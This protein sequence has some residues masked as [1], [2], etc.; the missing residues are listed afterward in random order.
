MPQI[1]HTW[2]TES[3]AQVVKE[4]WGFGTLR[5]H[6]ERAIRAGLDGRDSLVVMPTGGGKSLCYQVPPLLL[7]RAAVVVSPLI[8][9]MKD[10]VDGLNACG[11]PAAALNS[12]LDRVMQ[13]EIEE[14][15]L[16]GELRLL[17]LAPERLLTSRTLALLKEAHVTSFAID[18]AH[19]ISHWG[20]D[21]RP[22]YRRLAELRSY[23]PNASLHAFT[24]TATQ[25]VQHDIVEQLGLRDAELLVGRCDR[26]NLTYRVVPRTDV[27]KQTLDVIRRHDN[28]AMIIYCLSRKDTERLADWLCTQGV[29]ARAYHAGMGAAKRKRVQ[30]AFSTERLDIVVAT[31]AF[32]MGIDRSDVRC[33]VHATMPKSVE[34]YQQETGRAGRDGL[35]AECVLLYT[36]ADGAKWRSLLTQSARR[37]A[38]DLGYDEP[39]EGGYSPG[40]PRAALELQFQ[41]LRDMEGF[42][43]AAVC[44]HK[45]LSEYFGQ[46]YEP[47]EERGESSRGRKGCGACDVC[48]DE[49]TYM[50]GGTVIAQK[51]LSCV[52]RVEQRFGAAHVVDVLAGSNSEKI[53]KF[54]HDRLSTHGLMKDTPKAAVRQYIEQ[55]IAQRL[56][57]RDEGEYPTLRLGNEAWAVLKGEKEVS[58]IEV[59]KTRV[60]KKSKASVMLVGPEQELFEVLRTLRREIAQER[61][62]P[63]FVVFGDVTLV[64]MATVRPAE[65]EGMLGIKGIGREK[66]DS[67]GLVFFEAIDRFCEEHNLTRSNQRSAPRVERQAMGP[68]SLSSARTEAG[69]LFA[70]GKSVEIVAQNV[71]RAK[72][73]TE[74]YLVEWITRTRPATISAWVDEVTYQDVIRAFQECDTEGNSGRLK[75]V[76]EKLDERVPYEQIRFVVAHCRAMQGG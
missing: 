4:Y 10:Q 66:Q 45:S 43:S 52:A 15:F 54:N 8:S 27:Q 37:E 9:L 20:H 55:L 39:E 51:I 6:Q 46:P 76:H 53:R 49:I 58:L 74:Q 19:C 22:E 72:S 62:V 2:S 38:L 47:G 71:D 57:A 17:F 29:D 64:D 13:D 59:A 11:Y 30:E 25:R 69:E 56:I 31:V 7:G 26:P 60:G 28:Q 14:Q 36:G 48:L 21:F 23:F 18:E 12:T 40:D 16:R 65:L 32:G 33:V 75:S 70:Q 35:D 67:L 3:I 42:A 1:S 24:A 61:S 50:E 41:H 44:R 34:H 5:E 68:V 63:A 73:T